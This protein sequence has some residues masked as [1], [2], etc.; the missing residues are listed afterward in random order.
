MRSS[1]GKSNGTVLIGSKRSRPVPC[2]THDEP[3]YC[4]RY[5][6]VCGPRGSNETDDTSHTVCKSLL[7]PRLV[8]HHGHGIAEIEAAVVGLHREP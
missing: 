3:L 1:K 6:A 8:H 4:W 5:Y 2:A 7:P